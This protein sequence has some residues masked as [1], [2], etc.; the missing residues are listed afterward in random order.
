VGITPDGATALVGVQ[1]LVPGEG[2]LTDRGALAVFDTD[3]QRQRA[4]IDLPWRVHAIA[5]TPDGRRAVVNGGSGYAIVDL[6][7]DRLHGPPVPLV[8]AGTNNDLLEGAAMA[9]DGS[10]AALARNDEVVLVNVA[11]GVVAGRGSVV[12]S[13]DRRVQAIAWSADSTTVIAGS[14]AG[15]LHV[16]SAETL[17]PVAPPRLITGG[18]VTDLET[19]PDGRILASIGSDGDVTLWDTATWRPYGQPLTDDGLWGWLTFTADGMGLRV[20]FEDREVV[21]ISVDPA[22]WVAAACAAAGRNLTAAESAVIL[23]GQTPGE[24]CPDVA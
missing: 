21:D 7:T 23:P 12:E 4:V 15:W 14:D 2:L 6:T 10:T 1:G 9:P 22:D 19:S 8:V 20:F 16:V 13:E 3:T 18:W 24:T 17:E 11:S 5:V